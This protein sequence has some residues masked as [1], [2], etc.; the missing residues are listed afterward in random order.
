MTHGSS[1]RILSGRR[2]LC[3]FGT[4]KLNGSDRDYSS[5]EKLSK[6]ARRELGGLGLSKRVG[7]E[8]SAKNDK[9]V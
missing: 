4:Y 8:S 2:L 5:K 7:G 9:G 1:P 3:C 6:P